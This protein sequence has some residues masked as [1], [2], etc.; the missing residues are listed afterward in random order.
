MDFHSQI[1][2][3]TVTDAFRKSKT[4]AKQHDVLIAVETIEVTE[5]LQELLHFNTFDNGKNW[6]YSGVVIW[7]HL[8]LANGDISAGTCEIKTRYL[9]Q[10]CDHWIVGSKHV[11]NWVVS[12]YNI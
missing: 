1:P 5:E 2:V 3:I 9:E 8:A 6:S 4:T 11:V 10:Q 7:Q 12:V